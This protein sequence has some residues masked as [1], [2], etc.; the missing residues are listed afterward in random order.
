[1]K[2]N[3]E[4]MMLARIDAAL[5]RA[6]DQMGRMVMVKTDDLIALRQLVTRSVSANGIRNNNENGESV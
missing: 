3:E 6:M 2:G 1:M 5:M 4:P